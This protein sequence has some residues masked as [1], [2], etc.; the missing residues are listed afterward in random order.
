[1]I[2]IIVKRINLISQQSTNKS[3]ELLRWKKSSIQFWFYLH[4][5]IFE[6][7]QNGILGFSIP[8]L[9]PEIFRFLKYA[10]LWEAYD[11]IYS[12]RLNKIHKMRDI[13]ANN[14]YS[15]KCWNFAYV[16]G[17]WQ[18]RKYTPLCM[19][20]NDVIHFSFAYFKNL[21]ISGTR[22]SIEKPSMPFCLISKIFLDKIKIG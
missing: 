2:I 21:N 17:V 20:L 22:W 19:L 8:H 6:M 14:T 9:I 11:V 10:N 13:S 5:S 4:K 1:M 12:Q 3:I 15:R 18:W 16:Q 7:R